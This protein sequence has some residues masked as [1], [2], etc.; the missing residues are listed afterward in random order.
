MEIAEL[1]LKYLQALAWPAVAI[2][3]LVH[4]RGQIAA[5]LTRVTEASM[6]GATL[7]LEKNAERAAAASEELPELAEAPQE[8]GDTAPD[9]PRDSSDLGR[10]VFEWRA[11][12]S[13][14]RQLALHY[15]FPR[16]AQYNVRNIVRELGVR[17]MVSPET[18]RLAAQLQLLRNRIIHDH[19][20]FE[21]TPSFADSFVEA[22]RNLNSAL[23]VIDAR[24]PE[25][26]AES[27]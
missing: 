6:F 25:P 18:E 17:H 5:L 15:D 11:V 3:A 21:L 1:V 12:E 4:F 23:R 2:L 26:D 27:P 16:A 19:D 10:V 22:A 20:N 13:T 7:K 24:I 9:P 8:T 14:A